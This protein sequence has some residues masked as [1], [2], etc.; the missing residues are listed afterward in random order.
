MIYDLC[1]NIYL[2]TVKGDSKFPKGPLN[3]STF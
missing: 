1:C 2:S 3:E